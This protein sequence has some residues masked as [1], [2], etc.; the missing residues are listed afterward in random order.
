MNFHDTLIPL[1]GTFVPIGVIVIGKTL[2]KGEKKAKKLDN[3]HSEILEFVRTNKGRIEE[4]IKRTEKHDEDIRQ[5]EKE[6]SR[7]SGRVDSLDNR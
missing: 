1:L 2:D 4:L 3:N 6:I 7:L 5:C